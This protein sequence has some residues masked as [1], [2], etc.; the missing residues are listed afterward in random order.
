MQHPALVQGQTPRDTP[1][2]GRVCASPGSSAPGLGQA[3]TWSSGNP[4]WSPCSLGFSPPPLG[5]VQVSLAPPE[6]QG[7]GIS[8]WSGIP[9]PLPGGCSVQFRRLLL[10][11][12]LRLISRWIL[13]WSFDFQHNFRQVTQPRAGL[14][15]PTLPALGTPGEPLLWPQ[16]S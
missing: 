16:C 8:R 11:L 6:L 7:S 2:S 1:R 12:P 10:L 5:T 14:C 3:P 15:K 13:P 9:G 4:G